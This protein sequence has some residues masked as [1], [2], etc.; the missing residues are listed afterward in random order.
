M[1]R[2]RSGQHEKVQR[3]CAIVDAGLDDAGRRDCRLA[4][5]AEEES[6][7]ADGVN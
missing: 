4:A 1:R 3:A 2:S 7:E 6:G 5:D